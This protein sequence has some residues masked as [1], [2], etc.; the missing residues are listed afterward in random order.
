MRRMLLPLLCALSA[1]ALAGDKIA[2]NVEAA[3]KRGE[4]TTVLVSLA[5]QADL[6]SIAD[7]RSGDDRLVASVARLRETAARTQAPL[8]AYLEAR[9]VPYRAFWVANFI[10][11][12]ADAELVDDLAARADV[13]A[14]ELE[15][16]LAVEQPV[17]EQPASPKSVNAIET[18]VTQVNAP[19]LWAM[20]FRG[21]GVL[22]AG[23]D[24][25]YDW[26][27]PAIVRQYAGSADGA[28]DHNFHWWDAIHSSGGSC[29]GNS[30]APCD[31]NSHGT[32]TMG[33]IVGDDGGS[34]QIGVAPGARWIA[35]R[36]MDQGNG[37]PTTYTEC[38]QF[39]MAPTDL[40][41]NNPDPLR[42]PHVI[43]NSWGCPVSEGCTTPNILQTVVENVRNAGILVV[44]SAGNSGSS[45]SS[46]SDPP[47]IYSASFSVGAVG[48]IAMASF[49]SRG[50]VTVDGS[51]RLK[52]DIVAPGVN[53]RSALP[54]TGYGTK[55]GTSMA[56]PHVAGVAA[57]LMSVDPT[58]K[59]DPARIEALMNS[60]A[61]ADITTS[62]LCGGTQS[63]ATI[64][65][66]TF[67]HGRV[68]ALNAARVG[69]G[70]LKASGFE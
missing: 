36:N 69:L 61:V 26:D 34:N 27:H 66:N 3:L 43:N 39:F 29:P 58:L 4:R 7:K 47:S 67:G 30:A 12:Q 33:T 20:G 56:G 15:T 50:P 54:G 59:R 9:N 21:Q 68:D 37:T 24:T 41:G 57:L 6:K 49:S 42:A 65:N 22:V 32:H 17:A 48:G 35:C 44:V 2:A 23:A 13:A 28:A 18:G 62:Q 10:A 45:C 16:R 40:A 14:I 64:P 63:P 11:L 60:T 51:N 53:T 70:L 46:V 38:F 5:E 25:G 8:R 19:S 31:D 52:P 55:S 1:P